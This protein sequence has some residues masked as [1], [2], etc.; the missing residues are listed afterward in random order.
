MKQTQNILL[1]YLLSA[2]FKFPIHSNIHALAITISPYS[3]CHPKPILQTHELENCLK[4]KITNNICQGF[5]PS[6]QGPDKYQTCNQC[7]IKEIKNVTLN[8][9]CLDEKKE[10]FIVTKTV[11]QVVSCECGRCHAMTHNLVNSN[12]ADGRSLPSPDPEFAKS[13]EKAVKEQRDKID[14]LGYILKQRGLRGEGKILQ[15]EEKHDF[16]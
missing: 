9:D 8:F 11:E 4:Q 10:S 3:T 5:C 6:S 16:L 1:L 14:I 2:N 7:K 13:L 12:V 15:D